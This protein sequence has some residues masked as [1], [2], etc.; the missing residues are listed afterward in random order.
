MKIEFLTDDTLE[1]PFN[2]LRGV[3]LDGLNLHRAILENMDLQE[4]TFIKTNLRGALVANSNLDNCNLSDACLITAYFM[5]SSLTKANLNNCKAT[6][7]R[8]N[9][10]NLSKA[11]LT[12]VDIFAA[13][14]S[15]S[16]LC[17][18]IMMCERI[19]F[20]IFKDAIYS[21]ATIWPIGFD[22]ISAGCVLR[23]VN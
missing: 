13:D 10:A 17:G 5:N 4:T 2:S 3:S 12:G 23:S 19:E 14:F 21:D 20:A 15:N 6:G 22:P 8:F 11:N 9:G 16:N 18:A 7:C 1:L